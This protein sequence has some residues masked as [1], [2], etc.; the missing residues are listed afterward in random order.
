MWTNQ[1]FSIAFCV[2]WPTGLMEAAK[3]PHLHEFGTCKQNSNVQS[4]LFLKGLKNI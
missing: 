4:E 3:V 1:S 2:I